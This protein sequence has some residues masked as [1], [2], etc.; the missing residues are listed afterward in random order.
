[1][2]TQ[3]ANN[4]RFRRNFGKIKRIVDIPNLI[5]IQKRSYDDFLQAD[6]APEAA[7][8]YSACRASSSPSSRSRI[9][10]RRPRS[11]S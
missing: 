7:Q 1:M 6:A 11:S 3:V 2:A 4:L 8:G 5:D 9:S 10:T